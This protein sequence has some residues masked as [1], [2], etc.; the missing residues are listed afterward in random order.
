MTVVHLEDFRDATVTAKD[1]LEFEKTYDRVDGIRR[2]L[3]GLSTEEA[4]RTIIDYVVATFEGPTLGKI[5]ADLTELH[6]CLA[7]A[8]TAHQQGDD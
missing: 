7:R 6:E 8:R 4:A 5:V 3:S 1:Q 2:V